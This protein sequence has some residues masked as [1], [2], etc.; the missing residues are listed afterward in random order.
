MSDHGYAAVEFGLATGLLLLPVAI[1]VLSF[2]PWSETRVVAEAGAAEA[3]RAAAIHTDVTS[4][5]I[6]LGEI[7]ANHGI[8]ADEIRIGWCGN[9]A[10]ALD[11]DGGDCPMARGTE[12]S[13]E[14]LIW[15]PL[16]STPWGDV[17]GVWVEG[18]H[19]E[20]VDP[21]RSLG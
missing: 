3:A 2:G 13:V 9:P 5:V 4:G 11:L 8:G 19:S 20:P 18:F 1:A 10:V 16:I 17:G 6:V 12:V 7:A 21:Y 15:T 14:V